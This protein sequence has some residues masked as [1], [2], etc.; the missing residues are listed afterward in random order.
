MMYI[1]FLQA[2]LSKGGLCKKYVYIVCMSLNL[3]VFIILCCFLPT[4]W[5]YLMGKTRR[6][7]QKKI[8]TK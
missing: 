3:L 5:T 2:A 6:D 7:L 4:A 8:N 1:L